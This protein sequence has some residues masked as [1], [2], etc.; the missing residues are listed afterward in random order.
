[1]HCNRRQCYFTRSACT[2]GINVIVSS[3]GVRD[4]R[5]RSYPDD[6]INMHESMQ[7][8]W[9]WRFIALKAR[10]YPHIMIDG[11][12]PD[13]MLNR[14]VAELPQ[15]RSSLIMKQLELFGRRKQ[16]YTDQVRGIGTSNW[17][18]GI[19]YAKFG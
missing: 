19:Q 4:R 1:M 13:A 18:E 14:V 15:N 6:S 2:V 17:Q 3:L 16:K 8:Q 12:F 11:V 10:P 7:W 5:V 9:Q